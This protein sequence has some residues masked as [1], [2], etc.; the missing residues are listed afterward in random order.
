MEEA[1][2]RIISVTRGVLSCL[3]L[4]LSVTAETVVGGVGAHR[5]NKQGAESSRC[6]AGIGMCRRDTEQSQCEPRGVRREQG[7]ARPPGVKGSERLWA[8]FQEEELPVLFEFSIYRGVGGLLRHT[9]LKLD[10]TF[11]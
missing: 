5:R 4:P 3:F 11:F 6:R 1:G 9:H 2:G 7:D 8:S 10:L